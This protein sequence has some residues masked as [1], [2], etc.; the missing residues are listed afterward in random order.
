MEIGLKEVTLKQNEDL[1]IFFLGDVHFGSASTDHEALKRGVGVIIEAAEK[2]PTYVCL[3]GDL[4]DAI[5]PGD[6]RFSPSEIDERY[7]IKNLEDLPRLQF[8]DLYDIIKPISDLVI[9][10][11]VG[12]HEEQY[13][14]R[15]ANNVYDLYGRYLPNADLLGRVGMTRIKLR[16]GGQVRKNL[17]L[18]LSHGAGGGGF[19]EG[20]ATNKVFDVY[21]WISPADFLIMGHVHKLVSEPAE[22][23]GI[24]P[25]NNRPMITKVWHGVSGC[26]MEK[27]K[28]GCRNYFE[29][30]P[31]TL[32]GIGM[33]KGTAKIV[34]FGPHAEREWKCE[35]TLERIW[36]N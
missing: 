7:T 29:N 26:F 6:P 30:R 16:V 1:N 20:Y 35:T 34:R 23:F 10:T 9:A 13:I 15:H 11:V 18:A 28:E 5:I 4:I 12:N 17:D 19:R 2:N 8:M 22:F 36:L 3:M 24:S 32:P 31:G 25:R 27:H 14:K 21:R 33:L